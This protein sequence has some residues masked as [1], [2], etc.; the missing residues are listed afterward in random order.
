M[1]EARR[2]DPWIGGRSTATTSKSSPLITPID[3]TVIGE[4][5]E[6]D[7]AVVAEAA[8]SAHAAFLAHRERTPAERAAWLNEA[9]I[10]LERFE[11]AILECLIRTIG[12]P[13]RAATFEA[14]RGPQ[15]LRA[16]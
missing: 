9:A 5:A 12:K 1:A 11:S 6:C 10:Q 15:F 13:R 2:L 4:I 14:K 8:E 7:A 16:T 3:E